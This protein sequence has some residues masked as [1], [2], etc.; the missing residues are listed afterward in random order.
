MMEKMIKRVITFIQCM[1]FGIDKE[2]GMWIHPFCRIISPLR[3]RIVLGQ[4]VSLYNAVRID[5]DRDG[6][7]LL[8]NGCTLNVG[9]RIE[10]KRSDEQASSMSLSILANWIFNLVMVLF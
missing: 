5:C 8:K 1:R 6:K 2:K 9:T 10:G 3:G 7:V 4:D